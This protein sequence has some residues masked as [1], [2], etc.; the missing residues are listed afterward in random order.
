LET[1]RT[2]QI[3]IHLAERGHVVCGDKVYVKPAARKPIVDR[4]GA[5]R[6]ALH[7]AE[8]GFQ[9]PI[10]GEALFF[11]MPLPDDLQ[12]FVGRLRRQAGEPESQ[13]AMRPSSPR[14][15]PNR[16]PALRPHPPCVDGEQD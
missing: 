9:H 3:R 14:S 1:G 15:R 12:D 7:A 2:H 13:T 10:T 5:P 11:Q 8:L 16:R 4:S 6:Q